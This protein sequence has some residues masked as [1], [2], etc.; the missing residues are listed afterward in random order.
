MDNYEI[1]IQGHIDKRRLR[2]IA[3]IE[4]EDLPT[5]ETKITCRQLDQAALY[6]VLT[7][8]YNLGLSLQMVKRNS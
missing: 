1:I 2:G 3:S 4:V 6:A 8:I 5:G 7:K